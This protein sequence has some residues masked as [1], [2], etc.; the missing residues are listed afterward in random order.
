MF[1]AILVKLK[2]TLSSCY[3]KIPYVNKVSESPMIDIAH[4]IRLITFNT[5][6]E[7]ISLCETSINKAKLVRWSHWQLTTVAVSAI[8]SQ[9]RVDHAPVTFE[10]SLTTDKTYK[11]D[12]RLSQSINTTKNVFVLV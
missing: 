6:L 11:K 10:N 8:L 2:F 4:P 12:V 1:Y 3:L 5:T 7:L 9:P